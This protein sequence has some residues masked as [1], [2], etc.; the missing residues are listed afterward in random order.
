VV[1]VLLH[2]VGGAWTAIRE[3][4][5]GVLL[6]TDYRLQITDWPH[7]SGAPVTVAASEWMPAS[8][9]PG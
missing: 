9:S 7:Q 6:L 1:P 2:V 8:I 3:R 4:G 5:L